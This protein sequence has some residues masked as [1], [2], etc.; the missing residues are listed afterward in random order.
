MNENDVTSVVSRLRPEMSPFNILLLLLPKSIWIWWVS[1]YDVTS[2]QRLRLFSIHQL[3]LISIH[4]RAHSQFMKG[5]R[6]SESES[7]REGDAYSILYIQNTAL[8]TAL[9]QIHQYYFA[10]YYMKWSQQQHAIYKIHIQMKQNSYKINCKFTV[11]SAPVLSLS[12]SLS[13]VD[14]V[15]IYPL[16]SRFIYFFF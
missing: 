3:L 16:Y 8:A 15:E 1:I 10:V 4:K 9:K 12:L 2:N 6:K 11:C 7:E 13:L 14:G 5:E